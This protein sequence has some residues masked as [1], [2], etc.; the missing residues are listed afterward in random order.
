MAPTKSTTIRFDKDILNLIHKQANLA[1]KTTTE[2]ICN[3]VLDKLE[4]S[5]DY[6]AANN[7]VRISIF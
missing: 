5:P 7:E 3:T 2:F 1:K 4:N 6:Q